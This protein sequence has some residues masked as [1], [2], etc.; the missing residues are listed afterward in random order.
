MRVKV[1]V[2]VRV[3]GKQIA[4]FNSKIKDN[5]IMFQRRFATLFFGHGSQPRS[6]VI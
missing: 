4:K 2:R 5:L 3:A 6:L 1:A